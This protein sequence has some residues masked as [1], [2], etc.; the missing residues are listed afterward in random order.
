MPAGG[1]TAR[2]AAAGG[3]DGGGGTT[4]ACCARLSGD[5]PR[6]TAIV[7]DFASARKRSLRRCVASNTTIASGA[8]PFDACASGERVYCN[9]DLSDDLTGRYL[10]SSGADSKP[11]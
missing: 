1:A 11:R 5:A 7:P 2:G 9:W 6:G 8:A 4:A 3:G 10:H